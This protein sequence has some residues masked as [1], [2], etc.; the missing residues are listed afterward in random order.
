M[1][2]HFKIFRPLHVS[3][4]LLF[5]AL[6]GASCGFQTTDQADMPNPLPDQW[7]PYEDIHEGAVQ[8]SKWLVVKC[9]FSDD[10]VSRELPSNLPSQLGSLDEYAKYFLSSYGDGSGNLGDYI[11]DVTYGK[12]VLQTRIMGWYDADLTTQSGLDRRTKIERC[13]NAITDADAATIDF[14]HLDGVIA[15]TNKYDDGGACAVGKNIFNIKGQLVNLSCLIFDGGSLYT[16]FA[17]HELGHGLGLP[18]SSDTRLLDYTDAFDVMSALRDIRFNWPNYPGA[19][20]AMD[21]PSAG[22]G[23]SVPNLLTLNAIPSKRLET[24]TLGQA[25]SSQQFTLAALARPEAPGALAVEIFA[26]NKTYTLEYRQRAGWDGGFNLNLVLAHKFVPNG[27]PLSILYNGPTFHGGTRSGGYIAG[28]S[29]QN[30]ADGFS[31]TVDS[32]DEQNF[33]ANV[34]IQTL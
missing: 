20:A 5:I 11:R 3:C 32:I 29:W 24:Y 33:T 4:L 22:P 18:H 25:G 15:L 9:T 10:R 28:Q 31:V 23:M 19:I 13:L 30:V 17:A 1:F 8:I 2:G 12:I 27:A 16:G 21:L 34:T 7:T 26:N 14:E 6:F